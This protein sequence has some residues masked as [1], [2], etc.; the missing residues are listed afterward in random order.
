[1]HRQTVTLPNP[2]N[3]TIRRVLEAFENLGRTMTGKKRHVSLGVSLE[4]NYGPELRYSNRPLGRDWNELATHAG[5]PN[6]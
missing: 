3:P 2:I 4:Y 1:M 5:I 6:T